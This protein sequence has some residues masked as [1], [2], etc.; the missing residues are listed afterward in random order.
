MRKILTLAILGGGAFLLL[1]QA[2][3]STNYGAGDAAISYM[4]NPDEVNYFTD[5][6]N[7]PYVNEESANV[8]HQP[9]TIIEKVISAMTTNGPLTRGERNNNPGN[10]EKGQAWKGLNPDQSGDKRF[11]VFLTPE[12]GIRAIAKLL[13]NYQKMGFNTVRKM[14][15]RWAPPVENNTSAYVNSVTAAMGVGPDEPLDLIN[16]PAMMARMVQAIIGHENG[17]VSYDVAT[18]NNGISM[19]A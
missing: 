18:I 10:I 5:T 3:A 16:D 13:S 6:L 7:I 4:Y 12:Y 11:A 19:V 17:R 1:R 2:N 15:N 9:D 14:I 8:A